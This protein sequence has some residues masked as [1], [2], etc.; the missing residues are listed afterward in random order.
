MTTDSCLPFREQLSAWLDGDLSPNASREI[1]AHLETCASCTHD[2]EL[3]RTAIGALRC[4]PVPP[5]PTDIL[6]GLRKRLEPEPWYR[7]FLRPNG[8]GW[9][10]GMPVGALATVLVI[11]GVAFFYAHF[12]GNDHKQTASVYLKPG[13]KG[14]HLEDVHPAGRQPGDKG[15]TLEEP[16]PPPAP[17]LIPG[18][19]N[20]VP[21][22]GIIT[23][24][25]LVR[26]ESDLAEF[27]KTVEAHGGIV[28]D[29]MP[30]DEQSLRGILA[31]APGPDGRS[32]RVGWKLGI[33]ISSADLKPLVDEVG[34]RPGH[35]FLQSKA[36][37]AIPGMPAS[38]Q[39]VR[40]F[41]ILR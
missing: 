5:E 37:G 19:S 1:C 29:A 39:D 26:N 18:S 24:S 40:V 10:F 30:L 7:R 14:L 9:V 33:R 12:P 11:V 34:R 35:K 6:A 8:E 23:L 25:L 15:L 13:E 32:I 22:P 20:L 17:T 21:E 36:V 28:L 31:A 27:R 38:K 3:L 4:F 16:S 41:V 2:L